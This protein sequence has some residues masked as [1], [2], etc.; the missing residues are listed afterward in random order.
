MK[1]RVGTA[2]IAVAAIWLVSAC[3]TPVTDLGGATS[4]AYGVND[5]GVVVGE[6]ELP[7]SSTTHAFKRQSDNSAVDLGTLPGDAT[8]VADAINDAGV[9]VGRS[10]GEVVRWDAS[11]QITDLGFAAAPADINDAGVI[12]GGGLVLPSRQNPFAF[13][14]DPAVGHVVA[15]P[16]LPGG[17]FSYATGINDAGQVVGGATVDGEFVPLQ[18]DLAAGTVIDL[19]P[20]TGLTFANDIGNDGTIVGASAA[21]EVAIWRPGSPTIDPGVGWGEAYAVN[22]HGIVVGYT[23]GVDPQAFRWHPT[24]GVEWLGTAGED[25]TAHAVNST[26]AVVG[27][28]NQRAAFLFSRS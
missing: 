19:R 10:D 24:T 1:A 11:G 28:A 3:T 9:V 12:V 5:A 17:M 16:E 6:S 13:V 26:G 4:V 14:Y 8:S 21:Q 15:L 18:W 2:V 25:A 27:S 20:T 23:N 7:G 22:D